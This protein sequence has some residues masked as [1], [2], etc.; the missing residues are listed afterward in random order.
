MLTG[1]KEITVT[2]NPAR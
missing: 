1:H 2:F